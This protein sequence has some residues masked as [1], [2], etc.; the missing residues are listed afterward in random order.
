MNDLKVLHPISIRVFAERAV[1]KKCPAL[2]LSRIRE[3]LTQRVQIQG[4]RVAQ[5]MHIGGVIDHVLA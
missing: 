5:P 1:V 3:K 2:R 4:N